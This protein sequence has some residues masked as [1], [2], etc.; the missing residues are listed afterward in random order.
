MRKPSPV[1]VWS[2]IGLAGFGVMYDCGLFGPPDGHDHS[3]LIAV[4]SGTLS[5][6][7][8]VII[9]SNTGELIPLTM[10]DHRPP[11]TSKA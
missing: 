7:S 6:F 5:S 2:A 4:S 11:Q 8:G 3:V 1:A 10:P 9:A